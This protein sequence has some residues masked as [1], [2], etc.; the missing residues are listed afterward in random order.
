M[1]KFGFGSK[2]YGSG[3]T[4]LAVLGS[5]SLFPSIL[6][7]SD[8]GICMIPKNSNQPKTCI[9]VSKKSFIM[10]KRE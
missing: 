8:R 6:I 1:I 2:K 10:E 4:V 7:P 5:I 3:F 9:Q